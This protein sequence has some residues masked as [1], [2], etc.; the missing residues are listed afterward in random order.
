[1]YSARERVGQEDPVAK[2]VRA[3]AF[4]EVEE[5]G[6]KTEKDGRRKVEVGGAAPQAHIGVPAVLRSL[7]RRPWGGCCSLCGCSSN[8]A[9]VVSR[10]VRSA[11]KIDY[12]KSSQKCRQN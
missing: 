6:T 3:P 12:S 11:G 2:V 8:S 10:V 9:H 5:V 1:M 7:E 4:R